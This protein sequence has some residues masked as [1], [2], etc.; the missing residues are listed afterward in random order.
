MRLR[1][2]LLKD[3]VAEDLA[4]L[5]ANGV[6]E[7][8]TLEFKQ[9]LPGQRDDEKKE[10]LADVS[11]MANT[12]G[13]VILYGVET[14]RDDSGRDTGVANSLVGLPGINPDKERLRLHS[15]L[16]DGLSPSLSSQVFI[17]EIEGA[18]ECAPV[19]AIG[20]TRSVLAPH[21]V[22]FQRSGRFFRRSDAGKYQ[23]DITELRGMFLESSSWLEEVERFRDARVAALSRDS[24][25]SFCLIH[26]LALGRLKGMLDL[27]D[28]W[29]AL[30]LAVPPPSP[31]GWDHRFNAEGFQTYR[32]GSGGLESYSQCFRFGGFEGYSTRLIEQTDDHENRK[33]LYATKMQH[34]VVTYASSCIQA[35]QSILGVDPPYVLMITLCGLAGARIPMDYSRHSSSEIEGNLLSLPPVVLETG[36]L[37][38]P[39]MA[40]MFDIVW[41]SAGY[42]AAPEFNL[43]QPQG[44]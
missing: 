6:A 41:Q 22:T 42:V 28:K 31:S 38:K 11:S 24:N 32:R 39:E 36:S 40:T 8:K 14:L 23:P 25:A 10:F 16:N 18:G 37:S 26:L 4:A 27:R 15:L 17:R 44:E 5:A 9:S 12:L 21:M 2:K 43:N 20:L 34:V 33:Y 29:Q 1:G 30:N 35:L 19:V 13:G 7:S 3:V